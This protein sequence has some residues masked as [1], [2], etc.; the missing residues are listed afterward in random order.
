MDFPSKT[1]S[2]STS[3]TPFKSSN[4]DRIVVIGAGVLGLSVCTL[5]QSRLPARPV[6]LLAAELPSTSPDSSPSYTPSYASAWAGAH[7]RPISPST[8]QLHAEFKLAQRTFEVMKRIASETPKAGVKLMQ[9]V[10]YFDRPGKGELGMK[11]GDVYAGPEDGF[12]VLQ[13]SELMEGVK[14]GCEY[15]TYCINVRVYC[16]YL[17]KEFQEKGGKIVSRRIG[18]AKQAFSLNED[19]IGGEVS[20]VV[21]CSGTNF[22]KDPKIKLIRGQTVLVKNPYHRTLNRQYADGRWATLIPRPLDGGTIVGVTKE[23]GDEEETARPETRQLLLKQSIECFPDFVE[24]LEDFDVISDNVG[25]RPF[26]EGGVRME[27]E[28]LDDGRKPI[29]H[30][31]GTGGRGYELSWAIAEQLVELLNPGGAVQATTV[32]P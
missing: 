19:E 6:T 21:N 32:L 3:S 12:R 29:V 26:R 30:G 7:Y 8:P 15:G 2:A 9:G 13:K 28:E 27:V 5:L 14:W 4:D 24:K 23:I 31:Y 22:G 11:D 10:D 18:D 25:R 20:T 17:L 16:G 1:K